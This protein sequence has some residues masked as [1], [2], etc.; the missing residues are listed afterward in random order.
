MINDRFIIIKSHQLR[1][2]CILHSIFNIKLDWCSI[3]TLILYQST[4]FNFYSINNNQKFSMEI[5]V[6][7]CSDL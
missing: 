5:S 6:K 1:P 4:M 2:N 3:L 7:G